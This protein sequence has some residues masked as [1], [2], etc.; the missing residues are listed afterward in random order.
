MKSDDEV[1]LLLEHGATEIES[2]IAE[3]HENAKKLIKLADLAKIRVSRFRHAIT[4][5]KGSGEL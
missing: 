2:K 1:I 4:I 5:L 3:Y